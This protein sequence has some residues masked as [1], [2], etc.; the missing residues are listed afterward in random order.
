MERPDS[1]SPSHSSMKSDSS[2]IQPLRFSDEDKRIQMERPDSPLASQASMKSDSS[3]I[4]P[5]RLSQTEKRTQAEGPDSPSLSHAS[6]RSDS[7]MIQ[8]LRFS[9]T[10]ER[11]QIQ[12]P[13]SPSPSQVSMKSDSSMIQ[14]L[15]FSATDTKTHETEAAAVETS[16]INKERCQYHGRVLDMFCRTDQNPICKSCAIQEHRDH[17]KHYTKVTPNTLSA[18]QNM[19]SSMT[20]DTFRAL[21][22]HLCREYPECFESL[23]DDL[24]PKGVAERMMESF[25]GEDTLKVTVHFL[26]RNTP[27][28]ICMETVKTK[29]R[30]KFKHLHEG[31]E[32]LG[33]QS[34]LEDIYTQL[35]ITEGGTGEVN[36]EHEVRQIEAAAK[37][38]YAQETPLDLSNIFKAQKHIKT[39]L[40][41]GI[42]GVGKTVSVQKF[43]LDWAEG[44]SNQ[45]FHLILP[46]S[47]RDLNLERG[48]VC[49]LMGLLQHYFPEIK[50]I[51]KLESE[52]IKFL[53]I[54]DGLD[55]CRLSLD[56][57]N[58][59]KWSDIAKPTTLNVLLV[60]LIQGN[61]LPS[62][63]L[64][65]TSRPAAANQ[66]PKGCAQRVTE[67][68]GF[69]EKQ[70]EEYFRKKFKEKHVADKII[71]HIWSSRSLHIMCHIPVFCWISA[72]VLE[73]F[74]KSPGSSE[75]PKDQTQLYTHFL[76]IQTS[77]KN[78]KYQG[79]KKE[80]PRK[81]SETDKEMILKLGRLA[82]EEL[83]KGNLIFYEEELKKYG[84]DIS[85]GSQFSTLCTEIFKEEAGFYS[86][87]IFCFVHLS[88]QEFLA[89]LY[90]LCSNINEGTNVLSP[91]PRQKE[92]V[93]LSD[94]LKSA[95]TKAMQCKNGELDLFLRFLLGLS[96]D[97]NQRLLKGLLIQKASSPQSIK[98]TVKFIEEKI[99][100]QNTTERTI[101][102][103]HCLNELNDNS[104][105]KEM[106]TILHTEKLSDK[107]LKP[108]QC[109]ALAFV[110]L[111][112][113]DII[114][115]FD[116]RAF[117][118]QQ[119]GRQ[120][121][122]PVVK[123]AK[124]AILS[125][126]NITPDSCETVASALKIANSPV[127]ELELSY[128][129]FGDKG[130]E[131]LLAGLTSPHC[132]L[133]KLNL[134][135]C[136]IT[137]TSCKVL[138]S[139][140]ET[141]GSH[142]TC[143]DL[144]FNNLKDSGVKLLQ[145][146]LQS[147][148]CNLQKLRLRE[149]MLTKTSCKSLAQVLVSTTTKLTDLDLRDNNLK[150]SGVKF[151]SRGLKNQSCKLQALSLSGCQITKEGFKSLADALGSNPSHIRN[152]DL[153]YNYPGDS[154][155]KLIPGIAES[156]LEVKLDHGGESRIKSGLRK[157]ACQLTLDSNT[158]N[159]HLW[160]S[161]DK[162][163]VSWVEEKKEY[164]EHPGR[165]N[166]VS[167]ILCKEGLSEERFYWEVS[168]TGN[169]TYIGVTYKAE[170]LDQGW[171]TVFGL[172][173]KSWG[174]ECADNEYNI[175][176]NKSKTS[177]P[178]PSQSHTVGVYLDWKGGT[179]SFYNV[180]S[181][182]LTLLHTTHQTFTEP[183][184]PGFG[185]KS[186]RSTVS[187]CKMDKK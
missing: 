22:N 134:A 56:F 166:H 55:E 77:M 171:N 91:E 159:G 6:M 145:S 126:C 172:N 71:E 12:R 74:L 161:E 93:K 170:T 99:K 156:S 47:F 38:L 128:N 67:V 44:Q 108:D 182:N 165:F 42:A 101:N 146:G 82:F 23:E 61:L 24:D 184:Y 186:Q 25:S 155:M 20:A 181:G 30:I 52:N 78:M 18:L 2:M 131:Q 43:V 16:D 120:R 83:Q 21:K 143:L 187:L 122:L 135:G 115:E 45:D 70:K 175:C 26:T 168:W 7:S 84:I 97:S 73:T 119:V 176:H 58:S 138:A 53:L 72:T 86:K 17:K 139:V 154:D 65:I 169:G 57:Q 158:A 183:L 87:T 141:E 60:N 118:T 85:E 69:Q 33:Q 144:S 5:L 185:F 76:L 152:L 66:I 64:W 109:S 13:D 95:V 37:N 15:R 140:L 50:E 39:V 81:L 160:L 178:S 110:L 113:D 11:T 31:N 75:I 111:L 174:L 106:E 98:E 100:T 48:R 36:N 162:R 112:S 4:Q 163:Q 9:Q 32:Q 124:K 121:L 41:K 79:M 147:L 90:V 129:G 80:D 132:W 51:E 63:H 8:P 46:L 153:S 177:I 179:L 27:L 34:I 19:L 35:Y 29:L 157:Y 116:L 133:E 125:G 148:H 49:S 92:K 10:D 180:T 151:L 28:V 164:P 88:V 14:P 117:N 62:A 3:M 96:I 68:R 142:L 130:V 150:D 123:T 104:L 114:K 105:V 173:D 103:F 167:Q 40:T 94:V 59:Q 89:A 137:D 149:C 136:G 54:L 127:R 1:P 107:V 102:L